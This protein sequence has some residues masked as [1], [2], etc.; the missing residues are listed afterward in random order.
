M[1]LFSYLF[2]LCMYMYA[3]HVLLLYMLLMNNV[4]K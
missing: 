2:V 3:L 4:H 1:Y